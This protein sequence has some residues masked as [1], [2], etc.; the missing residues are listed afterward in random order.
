MKKL[1][2]RLVMKMAKDYL[3]TYR[4]SDNIKK[5]YQDRFYGY[6]HT[7]GCG[8]GEIY[9]EQNMTSDHFPVMSP[10]ERRQYIRK[11]GEQVKFIDTPQGINGENG[12]VFIGDG[13]IWYKGYSFKIYNTIDPQNITPIPIGIEQQIVWMGDKYIMFPSKTML[14]FV[15]DKD[16][17]RSYEIEFTA[18]IDEAVEYYAIQASNGTFARCS[19]GDVVKITCENSECISTIIGKD[20]TSS[21]WI[22][23][24]HD[25]PLPTG[26]GLS[27][28]IGK[29][30]I[31]TSLEAIET[32]I[33][34]IGYKDSGHPDNIN[35]LALHNSGD[36][37][38]DILKV[39]DAIRIIGATNANNNKIAIIREISADRTKLIFDDYAFAEIEYN[40]NLNLYRSVPNLDFVCA[41]DNRLWGCRGD[42]IYASKLGDPTN[43]NVFDG[44]ASDSYAA[45]VGSGGDF[46]ACYS[47]NGYPLF[48]KEDHIYKVYGTRPQNYQIQD[49]M[50]LGVEA[51]S[52]KSLAVAGETLY[53]KSRAGFMAYT[54]GVPRNISADLGND[55]FKYHS[56]VGG[57]NGV[58]YYVSVEFNEGQDPIY[59]LFTYDPR[60]GIWHKEDDTEAFGWA[61]YNHNLYCLRS[62]GELI[63]MD[64]K[65]G[66]LASPG[67][68]HSV[69]FEESVDSFVY[70]GDFVNN[71]PNKKGISKIQFRCEVEMNSQMAWKI[72]YDYDTF[73]DIID[74][75]TRSAN[76]RS[77]EARVAKRS[78]YRPLTPHRP[79]NYRLYIEGVGDWKLYSLSKD[80]YS[81]SELQKH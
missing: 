60:Y 61:Y 37:W 31:L 42:T 76:V 26:T 40:V 11:A 74:S 2:E 75:A 6:K 20:S 79:D 21:S 13:S 80:E 47:Y 34:D 59:I 63:V 33:C 28:T 57:S 70:F 72:S 9:D 54:G 48:F 30:A 16:D 73:E 35:E 10:R 29:L 81:G 32:K 78:F 65:N 66:Q 62:D 22:H 44:L 36:Q 53:Y 7:L 77:T 46:T 58:K 25:S 17:G 71:D 52:H 51:G 3:P 5:S 64:M 15:D 45:D 8:D 55:V 67:F 4:Y 19:I 27:M 24:T 43:F 56:A 1:L 68:P 41:H 23:V 69:A 38:S 50:T 12:L 14:T 49:T 18:Q 39:G